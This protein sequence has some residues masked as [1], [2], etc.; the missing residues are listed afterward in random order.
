[1]PLRFSEEYPEIKGAL[2]FEVKKVLFSSRSEFQKIEIVETESFGRVLIIDDFIML[3]ERDEFVY[4]EMIAHTPLFVHPNPEKVLIIGG[5]DGGTVRECCKHESVKRIDLVDIDRMVT[6]ACIQFMPA[7][8]EKFFSRRVN[9]FFEDGVAFVHNSR[10]RY[11]VIII[12][13]TDPISVGEGLFTSEFYKN[14]ANILSDDGILVAQS[15]SPFW[16]PE[17]LQ[18]IAKKLKSVFPRV[19]FYQ[20]HIPTYPSGQWA[21]SFA[22]KKYHPLKNF[23]ESLVADFPHNLQ[24][25]NA[26]IHRGAFAIPTFVRKLVDEV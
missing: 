26:E 6:Q 18:S 23:Q 22:T 10:E 5:G 4:H 15:E 21:F 11:E 16:T 7:V 14:C 2:N 24:Y 8:A 9:C 12:D 19:F 17:L 3:T 20:A 25:Y 1:M 13:S